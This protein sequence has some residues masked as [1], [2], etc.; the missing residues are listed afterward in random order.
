MGSYLIL[1]GVET[2]KNTILE[3][4]FNIIIENVKS[5]CLCTAFLFLQHPSLL[6]DSIVHLQLS[7]G[8][9]PSLAGFCKTFIISDFTKTHWGYFFY[10]IQ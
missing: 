3:K 10:S 1:G 7:E 8:A 5:E 6:S 4:L 2:G 9:N